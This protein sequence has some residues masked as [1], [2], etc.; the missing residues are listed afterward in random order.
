[1]P[2]LRILNCSINRLNTLPRGFGAFPVLEVLDLS[3]NNL[4]EKVLP[5]NFFMMDSLRAL[6]LGLRDNDLLELP[7]EI[8]ELTRIR[9]LHIQNNRLTVLPPE[10][11]SLDLLGQKSVLK[12]E[13]NPWVTAIAEQYLIGISHVLEYIK[14]EAYRILYN[15]HVSAGKAGNVPPKVDKSKK[16]SRARS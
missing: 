16:A 1:M 3:Y 9:E 15:R 5:G 10:I 12:M 2:K 6:S 8:G 14:T 4:S 11:A 13:E 7:R